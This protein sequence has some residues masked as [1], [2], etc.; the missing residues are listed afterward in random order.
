MALNASAFSPLRFA[1]SM[2]QNICTA[3]QQTLL[4]LVL[5]TKLSFVTD[6]FGIHSLYGSLV[7]FSPHT[8][9]S[10]GAFVVVGRWYMVLSFYFALI[11]LAYYVSCIGRRSLVSFTLLDVHRRGKRLFA[12]IYFTQIPDPILYIYIYHS[13]HTILQAHSFSFEFVLD[14][15]IFSSVT[16]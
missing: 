16:E 5:E 6:L 15:L 1:C 14:T 7:A 13:I 4:L 3:V 12:H 2:L 10:G 11:S 9:G 8:R